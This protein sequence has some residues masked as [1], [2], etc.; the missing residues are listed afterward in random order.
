MVIMDNID[1]KQKL[2]ALLGDTTMY[3]VLKKDPTTIYKNRLVI[4]RR[5][6]KKEGTISDNVYHKIYPTLENVPKFYDFPKIHKKDSPQRPIVSGIGSISYKVA[7]YL[8]VIL[9][10]LTNGF[11]IKNSEDFV[12]KIKDLK[13]PPPRKMVFYDISA[14]FTSI[15]VDEAIQVI[16]ERLDKDTSLSKRC[17]FSIDQ[18]TTL[19]EFCLN[20]TYFV[21]CL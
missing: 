18:V 3:E 10:P 14:L 16:H 17:K 5:E 13:L 12:N 1:Y 2:R 20:T 19:L 15:P 11:T 6:C 9:N 4:I 7:K 8:A 21:I